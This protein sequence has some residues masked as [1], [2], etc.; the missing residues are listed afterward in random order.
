MKVGGNKS[1]TVAF[2]LLNCWCCCGGGGHRLGK[3]LFRFILGEKNQYVCVSLDGS[4]YRIIH[5]GPLELV[6]F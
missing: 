3:S 4:L 5:I 6:H 1:G 2:A